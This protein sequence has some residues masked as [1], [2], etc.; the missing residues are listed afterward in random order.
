MGKK[1]VTAFPEI[2]VKINEK[3]FQ[4]MPLRFDDLPKLYQKIKN[5]SIKILIIYR[6][7]ES[8]FL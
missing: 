7:S 5:S 8:K 2:H 1:F 4:K 3:L 6:G